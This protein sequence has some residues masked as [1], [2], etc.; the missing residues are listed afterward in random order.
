MW[1]PFKR[2][3]HKKQIRELTNISSAFAILSEFNRRGLIHWQVKDNI[4]LIEES[5]AVLKLAEG[6]RKFRRFLDQVVSWQNFR[7]IR[8][9]Y[10]RHRIDIEGKAVVEAL[11]QDPRLT[12]ADIQRVR[13]N[14][15]ANMVE[16]DPDRLKVINEFDIFIIRATAQSARKA[17]EE[18][19]QLLAVG[20]YDG[21]QVEMAMYDDI[22]D[23]LRTD[24]ED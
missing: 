10:D 17:S 16:I 4:L 15:R 22:K 3:K 11:K 2:R 19:G 5:L 1:N 24:D 20:H 21:K 18:N 6:E 9:A 8:D 23:S 12:K 7:L 13:Q 14:A